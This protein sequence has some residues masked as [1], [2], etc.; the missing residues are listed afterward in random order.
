MSALRSLFIREWKIAHRIGGGAA[1]GVIFFL[2]LVTVA[3]FAIGPLGIDERHD[4][5]AMDDGLGEIEAALVL[6]RIGLELTGRKKS[7]KH[8]VVEAGAKVEI[9]LANVEKAN[10]VPE[11]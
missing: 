1:V 11:F 10:L 8:D 6:G 5:I 3:P 7:K 9:E 2:I 4:A